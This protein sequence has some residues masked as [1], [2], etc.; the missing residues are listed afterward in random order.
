MSIF[1]KPHEKWYNVHKI[2]LHY[3]RDI[4][5]AWQRASKG[6]CFRDLWSINDWFIDVFPKMLLDFKNNLHGHPHGLTEEE[7]NNIIDR[8]IFC[9]NE[10]DEE[11]CSYKNKYKD[12]F[13]LEF[14][15]KKSEEFPN[16][17]ELVEPIMTDKEKEN[18]ELWLKEYT[19][20]YNY[21]IKML[22]EGL[23]LFKNHFTSLWD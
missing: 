16:F 8:I 12:T 11:K 14:D 22:N 23:E 5:C 3:C 6:Y 7:W 18:K 21:R 4:E 13:P 15:F 1:T 17:N 9:L 20:I 2:I 10:Y 19:N